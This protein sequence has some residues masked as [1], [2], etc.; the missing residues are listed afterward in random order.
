M[1]E[2]FW[3]AT[4]DRGIGKNAGVRQRAADVLGR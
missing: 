3:G 1:W 2:L 4:F